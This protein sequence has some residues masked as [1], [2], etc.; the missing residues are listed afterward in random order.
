ML[1]NDR[2]KPYFL[3]IDLENMIMAVKNIRI[4]SL[5]GITSEFRTWPR[6]MP[7]RP[8]SSTW[9]VV[10]MPSGEGNGDARLQGGQ[11]LP[12][13]QLG[14]TIHRLGYK[15]WIHHSEWRSQIRPI[16][17]FAVPCRVLFSFISRCSSYY[18]PSTRAQ[19]PM[20]L[21]YIVDVLRTRWSWSTIAR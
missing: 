2:L 21:Y 4:V 1:E 13:Q 20:S 12:A 11:L 19:S 17:I 18:Q 9:H 3:Q 15:W 10:N 7:A 5:V 6:F 16:I 14:G 8:W